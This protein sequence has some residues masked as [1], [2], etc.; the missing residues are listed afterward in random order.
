MFLFVSCSDIVNIICV[1][2]W[3]LS[4]CNDNVLINERKGLFYTKKKREKKDTQCF[5]MQ[6][7]DDMYNRLL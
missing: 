5:A 4:K 3:L 6:L 7:I 2:I 1:K